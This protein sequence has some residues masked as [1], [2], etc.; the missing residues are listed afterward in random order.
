MASSARNPFRTPGNHTGAGQAYRPPIISRMKQRA[1]GT[2]G[3]TVSAL[4][5]GCMTM[6]DFYE[7]MTTPEGRQ[8]GEAQSLATIR[9]ALELGVNFL[10]SADIY[11]IGHNEELVGRAVREHVDGGGK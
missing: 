6:S 2:S 1:L 4:G 7:D 3:V 8:A 10:D 9:R 5:L 11:G